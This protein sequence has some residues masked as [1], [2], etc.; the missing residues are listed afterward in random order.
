MAEQIAIFS[1]LRRTPIEL[2]FAKTDTSGKYFSAS[3]VMANFS[4]ETDGDG[5]D[6]RQRDVEP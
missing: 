1:Q 6:A 3:F 4:N 2:L 5:Q